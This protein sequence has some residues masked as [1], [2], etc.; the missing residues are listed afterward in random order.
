MKSFIL[1]PKYAYIPSINELI[2]EKM[3][4]ICHSQPDKNGLIAVWEDEE[5]LYPKHLESVEFFA[6]QAVE[7]MTLFLKQ[8]LKVLD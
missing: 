2:T 3:N 7:T 4:K 8:R 1:H 5:F 6:P